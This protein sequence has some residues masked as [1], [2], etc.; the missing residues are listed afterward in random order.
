[1]YTFEDFHNIELLIIDFCKR[2]LNG[3][4]RIG[5]AIANCIAIIFRRPD[6]DNIQY[7]KQLLDWCLN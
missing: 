6:M 1:M 3:H 7:F 2:N 4:A 5:K